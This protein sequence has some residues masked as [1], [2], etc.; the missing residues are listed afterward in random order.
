MPTEAVNIWL[1]WV[2]DRND[3]EHRNGY[4]HRFL[5]CSRIIGY[6]DFG[7]PVSRWLASRDLAVRREDPIG[8]L[9]NTHKVLEK[10]TQHLHPVVSP[11]SYEAEELQHL[12][13]VYDCI[14]QSLGFD[15][16]ERF[17][18]GSVMPMIDRHEAFPLTPF[19]R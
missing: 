5:A 1:D 10:A 13:N 2:D 8:L 4:I 18:I 7:R 9:R 12:N 19:H 16:T 11:K 6:K 3:D 14:H 15:N 17:L